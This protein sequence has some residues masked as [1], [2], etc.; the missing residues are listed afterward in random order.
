MVYEVCSDWI[1]FLFNPLAQTIGRRFFRCPAAVAVHHFQKLLSLK[2]ELPP[3]Y[4]VSEK[5]TKHVNLKRCGMEDNIQRVN[6]V[7]H[8]K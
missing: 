5:K 7:L 3:H 1:E 8:E 4:T 2:F 6:C